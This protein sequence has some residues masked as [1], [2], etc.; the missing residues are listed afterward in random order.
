[1]SHFNIDDDPQRRF[2][3]LGRKFGLSWLYIRKFCISKLLL[4]GLNEK[5]ITTP[6]P[7]FEQHFT[8]NGAYTKGRFQIILQGRLLKRFLL[9][10]TAGF[11]IGGS[12]S[13]V[14]IIF[15]TNLF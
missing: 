15:I 2:Q 10:V 1:M 11:V 12:I 6:D 14:L 5:S 8:P 9:T 3:S 4:T 13:I 7:Q